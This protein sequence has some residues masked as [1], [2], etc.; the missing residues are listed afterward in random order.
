MVNQLLTFYI[1]RPLFQKKVAMQWA[2]FKIKE[3]LEYLSL[4]LIYHLK[5]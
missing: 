5:G 2:I 4:D 1:M 3:E